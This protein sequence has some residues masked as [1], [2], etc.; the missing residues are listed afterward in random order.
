MNN[1]KPGIYEHYKGKHYLVICIANHKETLEELVIYKPLYECEFEY[2]A[3]P[4]SEF[5]GLVEIDGIE[6]KRF[7]FVE[8]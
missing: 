7:I 5:T 3:R 2:F 6:R 8:K 4:L 1:L